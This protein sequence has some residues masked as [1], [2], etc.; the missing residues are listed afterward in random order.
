MKLHTFKNR[1]TQNVHDKTEPSHKLNLTAE[2]TLSPE[3]R[4][5]TMV[6]RQQK[7]AYQLSPLADDEETRVI[8]ILTI[9]PKDPPKAPEPVEDEEVEDDEEEE[10]V[11]KKQSKKP[12]TVRVYLSV[13]GQ[14]VDVTAKNIMELPVEV[15]MDVADLGVAKK[16]PTPLPDAIVN[17]RSLLTCIDII[18]HEDT[19]EA[20]LRLRTIPKGT[21]SASARKNDT[22]RL[23]HINLPTMKKISNNIK[24]SYYDMSNVEGGNNSPIVTAFEKFDGVD[25]E[26]EVENARLLLKPD[27][28]AN[29]PNGFT[30][31][32]T[33]RGVD[34]KRADKRQREVDA[35]TAVAKRMSMLDCHVDMTQFEDG[36]CV[37]KIRNLLDPKGIQ[38]SDGNFVIMGMPVS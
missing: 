13:D 30:V 2:S 1:S 11:A 24:T 8:E 12:T 28:K 31:A 22:S 10:P 20:F 36:M 4:A 29:Y 3:R 6:I 32:S 21:D 15:K 18:S 23:W 37:L 17:N 19:K 5:M 33:G 14:H 25:S 7:D 16:K 27:D 9:K 26:T 35:E 34:I 38:D